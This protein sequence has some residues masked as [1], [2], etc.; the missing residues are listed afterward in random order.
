MK[1]RNEMMDRPVIDNDVREYLRTAQ[2]QLDGEIGNIE[3]WAN[4]KRVPIIPHETVTFFNWLLPLLQPKEILEI[5]TAIGFSA[6]L[7]IQ[8]SSPECHVTTIERNPDMIEKAKVNFKKMNIESNV[9][10]LEGQASDW[11]EKLKE[12]SV[13]FIFMDSAKAKYYDFFPH[14]YR[15]LKQGG[16][17]AIDD[18]LQGGTILDDDED[19]PRRR[20]KIHKKLN[21]FLDIVM[22]HPAFDSSVVPLGDGLLLITKRES[23]DFSFMLPEKTDQ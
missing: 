14:C 2:K 1:K 7:M 6:G 10:L 11:L 22:D 23:F 5:G 16:V 4:D 13:D 9:T 3:K 17:L 18:V 19:V 12:E 20:R 15:L 21:A 8:A